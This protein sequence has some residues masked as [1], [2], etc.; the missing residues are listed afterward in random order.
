MSNCTVYMAPACEVTEIRPI[1]DIVVRTC[2]H[3]NISDTLAPALNVSFFVLSTDVSPCYVFPTRLQIHRSIKMKTC[4]FLLANF[5][6]VFYD[7]YIGTKFKES[8]N[9]CMIFYFIVLF[10]F[11]LCNSLN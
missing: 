1:Y 10:Y 11:L 5:Y 8:S 4:F 3:N 7:A 9:W 6:S 2:C